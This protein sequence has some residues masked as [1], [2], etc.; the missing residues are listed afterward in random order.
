MLMKQIPRC[1]CTHEWC[2]KILTLTVLCG[3]VHASLSFVLLFSISLCVHFGFLPYSLVFLLLRTTHPYRTSDLFNKSL[4][5]QIKKIYYTAELKFCSV[6][7]LAHLTSFIIE[8]WSF[9]APTQFFVF[10]F[11]MRAYVY[12]YI[13]CVCV[14]ISAGM[15]FS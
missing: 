12:A 3:G 9:G 11:Y 13:V 15:Y 7:R 5:F 6:E 4:F 1:L 10:L 2:L 14:H 8:G